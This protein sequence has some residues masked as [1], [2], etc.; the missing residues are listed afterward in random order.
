MAQKVVDSS[1]EGKVSL[2]FDQKRESSDFL[3][4]ERLYNRPL[5]L[6]PPTRPSVRQNLQ[7]GL[8]H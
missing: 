8:H 6:T 4:A 1:C 5:H 3:D 7:D 2:D